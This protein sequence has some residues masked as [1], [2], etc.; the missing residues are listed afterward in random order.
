[1]RVDV[2]LLLRCDLASQVAKMQA[3][4]W[5]LKGERRS[6][7]E[8]QLST[9]VHGGGGRWLGKSINRSNGK[10]I[11]YSEAGNISSRRGDQTDINCALK[12]PRW[13]VDSGC[14][15]K[16][17]ARKGE[18]VVG[19]WKL[20]TG[21][22]LSATPTPTPNAIHQCQHVYVR[23]DSASTLL[24]LCCHA[25]YRRIY[26]TTYTTIWTTHIVNWNYYIL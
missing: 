3:V 9:G 12:C 23:I 14:W 16:G 18:V 11:I 20:K 8:L 10:R 4:M 5:P 19:N 22:A 1:M 17:R 25:R 13:C 7:R 6:S 26:Y 24:R 21:R 2:D 15:R